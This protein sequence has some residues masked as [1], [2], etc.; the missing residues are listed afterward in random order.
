MKC[1]NCK[2]YILPQQKD[3]NYCDY[4]SEYKV[5]DKT[6]YQVEAERGL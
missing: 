6:D 2:T 1:K 4:C 5:K 3:G